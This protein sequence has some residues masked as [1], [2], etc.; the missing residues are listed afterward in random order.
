MVKAKYI[1]E[2]DIQGFFDNVDLHK[3]YDT[4]IMK[5]IPRSVAEKLYDI[6][7]NHPKLPEELKM[8]ESHLKQLR[9]VQDDSF[10]FFKDGKPFKI[11][12]KPL[13]EAR[14]F[15]GAII[16]GM[17]F[18]FGGTGYLR[19]PHGVPQGAP[20]S[21]VLAIL[22]LQDYLKQTPSVNYADDQIFYSDKKFVI[23]DNPEVGIIHAPEK[24]GWIRYNG[25]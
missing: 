5:R 19:P 10:E 16:P 14:N 9:V 24:C 4:L 6:C 11:E 12:L 17:P 25:E 20:T 7:A 13:R 3:L 2:T 22:T 21:P 18:V 8:D 15:Q 1:Y 23:K